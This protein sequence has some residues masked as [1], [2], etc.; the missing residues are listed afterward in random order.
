MFLNG[1]SKIDYTPTGEVRI[2]DTEAFSP[3]PKEPV[4]S[5]H[6]VVG[7]ASWVI[8]SIWKRVKSIK[9]INPVS[10]RTKWGK[11]ESMIRVFIV[12]TKQTCV[13]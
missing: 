3:A 8:L 2:T 5:V 6:E 10:P 13:L 1:N 11:E 7:K 9:T 4:H 12:K